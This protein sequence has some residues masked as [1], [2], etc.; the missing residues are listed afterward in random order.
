MMPHVME[1]IECIEVIV[2]SLHGHILE[3]HRHEVP[4]ST[5]IGYSLPDNIL[6]DIVKHLGETVYLHLQAAAHRKR[7]MFLRFV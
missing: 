4:G 6:P 1:D 5:L 2:G 7:K 3:C